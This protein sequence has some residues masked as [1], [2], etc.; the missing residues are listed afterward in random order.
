MAGIVSTTYAPPPTDYRT[1]TQPGRAG[2]LYGNE[3]FTY[4]KG[5]KV[6]IPE[7]HR[8]VQAEKTAATEA[9]RQATAK[10]GPGTGYSVTDPSGVSY[11]ATPDPNAA[12]TGLRSALSGPGTG[13]TPPP[14]DPTAPPPPTVNPLD[15]ERQK[16]QMRLEAELAEQARGRGFELQSQ[17]EARRIG[18]IPGLLSQ[19]TG[20]G[21]GTPSGGQIPFDE[22]GAR[23]A[24]FARAKDQAGAIS[25][26]ALDA[27]R[28]AMAGRGLAGSG[29]EA[30]QTGNLLS[31][32]AG[33]LSDFT[34]EQLIQDL[35]RS[36][37]ISDRNFQGQLTRRGQNLS[38]FPSLQGLIAARY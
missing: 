2:G 10:G 9:A 21:D 18:Q 32:G 4:Y 26:S 24:A 20:I 19:I 14:L 17:A 25:R 33:M 22:P 1:G 7:Y 35:T 38:L 37:Q 28:E 13:F 16:E 34:R 31:S 15:F 27:L 11:T 3:P 30:E 12:T 8:L 5:Q 36:G 29:I 6:S 23:A